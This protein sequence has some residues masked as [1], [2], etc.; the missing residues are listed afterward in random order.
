MK[1]TKKAGFLF[2][3]ALLLGLPLLCA[4]SSNGDDPEVTVTTETVDNVIVIG[5]H[6]DRTGVAS[7]A[8]SVITYAIEDMADR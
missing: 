2:L 7:Q 5:N 8:M 3:A 1:N 4:C 6:T